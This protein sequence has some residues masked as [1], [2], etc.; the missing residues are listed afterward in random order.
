MYHPLCHMF[1]RQTRDRP[2]IGLAVPPASATV[3]KAPFLAHVELLTVH[4]WMPA[5]EPAREQQMPLAS[6]AGSPATTLC[7][8]LLTAVLT[9][10]TTVEAATVWSPWRRPWAVELK[11]AMTAILSW[12][13]G[14][15]RP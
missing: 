5:S 7:Q 1:K 11:A 12:S 6:G 13:H 8:S 14:L 15:C 10:W 4:V 2:T 9:A 3:Q